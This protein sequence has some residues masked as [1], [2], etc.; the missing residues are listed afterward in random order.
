[1]P[2][3]PLAMTVMPCG[4]RMWISAVKR[5]SQIA[6]DGEPARGVEQ[7]G[8]GFLNGGELEA[9]DGAVF[10]A[11]DDAVI[12]EGPVMM[13]CPLVKGV[14]GATRM[15]PS[16]ERSPV[17]GFA[18]LVG[19][20]V[21]FQRGVKAEGDELHVFRGGEGDLSFGGEVMGCGVDLGVD[22]IAG[23]VERG[24]L[25]SL[26]CKRRRRGTPTQTERGRGLGMPSGLEETKFS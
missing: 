9:F 16:A 21:D 26:R 3:A 24:P 23:D 19:D 1:M 6:G 8:D 25:G 7:V 2:C 12:I 10:G 14:A 5:S 17:R 11:G 13:T 4:T 18:G 15:V 22:D 20:F